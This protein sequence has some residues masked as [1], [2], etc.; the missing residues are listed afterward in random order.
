MFG[1]D[2]HSNSASTNLYDFSEALTMLNKSSPALAPIRVAS[3]RGS[4]LIEG[5]NR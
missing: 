5:V 1:T 4:G 3:V 2:K